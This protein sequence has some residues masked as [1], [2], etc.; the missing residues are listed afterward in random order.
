LDR[1]E[2]IVKGS[3]RNTTTDTGILEERYEYDAFGRPYQ[4][5]LSGVMNP[6]YADSCMVNSIKHI[7]MIQKPVKPIQFYIRNIMM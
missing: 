1:R 7:H 3:V 2:E 4:G 6:W 5:D